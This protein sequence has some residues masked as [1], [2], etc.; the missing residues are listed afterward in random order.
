MSDIRAVVFD[1]GGVVFDWSA[2]YLY[3]EL[4]PD[5]TRRKWFLSEVC[6]PA[7]NLQQ[8]GGRTGP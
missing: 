2:E 5:E 8:D 4:I 7:W 1:F 6:T 3:R